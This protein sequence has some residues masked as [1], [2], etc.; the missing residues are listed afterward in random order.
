MGIIQALL[1]CWA[2]VLFFCMVIPIW[3][4]LDGIRFH[5]QY[6]HAFGGLH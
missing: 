1:F 6:T 3:S 2:S 5:V 4:D